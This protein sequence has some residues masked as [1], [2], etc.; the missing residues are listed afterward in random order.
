M[1]SNNHSIINKYLLTQA[2]GIVSVFFICT[3]ILTFCLK[4]HP[5]MRVPIIHNLTVRVSEKTV[6]V[7]WSETCQE[8]MFLIFHFVRENKS[9][10]FHKSELAR[11]THLVKLWGNYQQMIL[12]DI[13]KC[14]QSDKITLFTCKV[15]LSPNLK[16]IYLS[17]SF[18]ELLFDILTW[19]V[20]TSF[21]STSVWS[22]S[23]N[24]F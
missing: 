23:S 8:N 1:Q 5:D 21:I 13:R 10:N 6:K 2:V 18:L 9:V 24:L 19:P 17:F 20:L 7:N 11:L 15:W 22:L 4:T 14:S 12:P 3:S 16:H